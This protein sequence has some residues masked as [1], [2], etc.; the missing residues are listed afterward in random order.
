MIFGFGID[1]CSCQRIRDLLKKSQ[2]L[3]LAKVFTSNEKEIYHSYISERRQEEFLAGRWAAKE[4]FSKALKVG[5][6][7]Y[8][9]FLDLEIVY[10]EFRRP[11]F[12]VKK[13]SSTAKYCLE[14]L[15]KNYQI[16]ISIT[17]ESDLAQACVIL[18]KY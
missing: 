13:N 15:G 10:D 3:F 17:H 18:E 2:S 4:A 14:T 6:G 1:L 7:K 12:L 11:I 9:C 8:C 16:H 5:I